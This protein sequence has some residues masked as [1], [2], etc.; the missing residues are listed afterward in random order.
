MC[1]KCVEACRKIFPEVPDEDM[2]NFLMGTTCYPFG[3]PEDVAQQLASNRERMTT[4]D[5]Q[6]CY[7]IADADMTTAAEEAR[8]AEGG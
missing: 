6:E 8:K 3:G 2:C 1:E 4:S 5:W 7:T